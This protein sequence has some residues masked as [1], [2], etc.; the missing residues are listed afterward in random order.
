VARFTAS[1]EVA[2]PASRVWA[3]LVDWAGHGRWIPLTRVTVLTP[4]GDGVGARFVGRTAVGPLGFDDPMQVTRWEPPDAGRPGR[5]DVVKTGRL[6][7]GT[8]GFVVVPLPGDRSRVEWTEDVEVTPSV[9]TRPLAPV[10]RPL[11][12]WSFV[13]VL[14]RMAR[15]VVRRL[16]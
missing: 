15:D 9:L 5:C 3:A 2:A 6:L 1:V 4:S 12:R 16:P 8:A 7:R 14:R 11:A 13:L 10:W